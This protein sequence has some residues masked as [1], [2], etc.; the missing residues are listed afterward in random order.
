MMLSIASIL[1]QIP[2]HPEQIDLLQHTLL[3]LVIIFYHSQYH[4]PSYHVKFSKHKLVLSLHIGTGLFEVFEYRLRRVQL[5]HDRILPSELDV[6]SCLVWSA[7]SLQLVKTLRRGDPQTTRP[8]YQAGAI[9]RPVV[10]VLAYL[11]QS[12]DLHRLSIYALDSFVYARVFIFFFHYTPYLRPRPD[13]QAKASTVEKH[14]VTGLQRL[15]FAELQELR[16]VTNQQALKKPLTD[17]YVSSSE[18]SG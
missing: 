3:Y 16:R 2:Q 4:A 12:P 13:E 10:C 17:D 14:L 5:A 15:G 6:V 18:A 1:S 9:L 7:T 8:P 11:L